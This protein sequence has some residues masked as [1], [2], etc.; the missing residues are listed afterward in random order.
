[1][2]GQ[3][4]AGEEAEPCGIWSPENRGP[5]GSTGKTMRAWRGLVARPEWGWADHRGVSAQCSED[6]G[7]LSEGP[8]NP[9][10][11]C[12]KERQDLNR[13]GCQVAGEL[14]AGGWKVRPVGESVRETRENRGG[15]HRA[16]AGQR[17]KW[18]VPS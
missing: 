18:P 8:G 4:S 9:W 2:S 17:E 5:A 11:L 6:L 12:T 10:E 15:S 3:R 7:F 14:G 16:G 1:M 13:V